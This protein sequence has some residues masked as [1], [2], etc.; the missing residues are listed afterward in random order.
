[1]TP[2]AL[3]AELNRLVRLGSPVVAAQMAQMGMAVVDTI[4]A[5]RAS[6]H[7][8][9]GVALGGTIIWP[10]MILL[11]GVLMAL[12]PTISRLHGAGRTAE[13]GEVVRQGLWLAIATSAAVVLLVS[14]AG[15]AYRL[16]GVDPDIIPLAEQYVRI[17]SIGLPGVMFFNVFRYLC[18]GLGKTRPAMVVAFLALG[19]K[20]FLN[21]VFVF[22]NLGMPAMGGIGCAWSTAITMWFEC[23]AILWV[24]SRARYRKR[25][26][27]FARFSMP[28]P[29]RIRE[30]VRLGVPIG[31]TAFFE[32]AAFSM[33]TL[34]AARLGATAVAAQQ[35]AFSINGVAFM[36][37]LG[38]GMAASIRVGHELGAG[39]NDGARLAALVAL[40]ASM[41]WALI[42]AAVLVL[43]REA[44]IGFFTRDAEVA[45][46]G[47]Q[48]LL[49]VALYQLVDDAQA[50]AIGGLRGYKDTRTPMMIALGGYW[51][52]ALP[53]G[54]GL[55][56]GWFGIQ[57]G[58]Y[59][60]WI[61]LSLGLTVVAIA[62]VWRLNRLSQRPW[63]YPHTLASAS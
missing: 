44:I 18:D 41:V 25:T 54:A 6:A 24:V 13:T 47:A 38:L 58:V 39:R 60:F 45:A 31:L 12:T 4:M 59:G 37:P 56:L 8:L 51:G 49:F 2:G 19:L 20:V 61:G 21:W 11:M 48:L 32:F 53:I 28:D 27:L 36:I 17:A 1:M 9:A 30:L 14:Q 55:G 50:T 3:G 10:S 15:T 57:L 46:L 26:G 35:I 16:I 62:V 22:G 5:G 63:D 7:D 29:Q 33:V 23:L 40:G 52:V 43:G 34:L 42:A